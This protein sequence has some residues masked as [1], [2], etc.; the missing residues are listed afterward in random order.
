MF[1]DTLRR[2]PTF[3]LDQ[4]LVAKAGIDPYELPVRISLSPMAVPVPILEAAEKMGM[5]PEELRKSLEKVVRDA[6]AESA[7]ASKA[8]AGIVAK[9]FGIRPEDVWKDPEKAEL[10]ERW[11]RMLAEK[12]TAG[13][14]IEIPPEWEAR[15][16]A[17][18]RPARPRRR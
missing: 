2:R 11:A 16:R 4:P 5:P 6:V 7:W 1:I 8:G 12:V 14:E 13:V 9:M 15:L 3:I 10:A 17:A 18:A